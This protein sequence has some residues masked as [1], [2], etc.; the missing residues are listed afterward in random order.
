[1]KRKTR[2]IGLTRETLSALEL[3]QI[4]GSLSSAV[5]GLCTNQTVSAGAFVCFLPISPEM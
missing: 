3:V 5:D 2:R 1:M 4:E